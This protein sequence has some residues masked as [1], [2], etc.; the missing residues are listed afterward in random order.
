MAY[1]G[2]VS[3]ARRDVDGVSTREA[4]A[5]LGVRRSTLSKW[6]DEGRIPSYTIGEKLVRIRRADLEAFLESCRVEPGSLG[7]R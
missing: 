2:D 5:L 7:M 3:L 6:L 1:W 4:A